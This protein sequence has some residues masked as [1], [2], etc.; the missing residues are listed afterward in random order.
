MAV[1][2]PTTPVA[3]AGGFQNGGWYNGQQYWNGSFGAPGQGNNPNQTDIYGKAAPTQN[4]ADAAYIKQQQAAPVNPVAAPAPVQQQAQPV[5]QPQAQNAAGG[6]T[7]ALPTVPTFDVVAATNAAYNTPEITAAQT[8]ITSRQ[9]A[10]ATA[11]AGINDNPFYSEATR[12]GKLAK[13]TTDA[14]NDIKVQQDNLTMLNANAQVKLNA[15]KDQYNIN[16]DAYKTNLTNFNSLVSQGALDNAS[17]QDIANMAIQTGIPTSMIQSIQAWSV[18][19][20][21]PA[22]K[23]TIVQSTDNSGNLSIMAVDPI[24]GKVIS[25]T[26]IAGAGKATTGAGAPAPKVGSTDYISWAKTDAQ[27]GKTLDDMMAYYTGY[28]DKQQ[29]FDLYMAQNYYK[30]SDTQVAAAKTKWGVK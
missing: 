11:T 20:D 5:A 15:Q 30:N 28:L 14:N 27:S 10:L 19:K 4:A 1:A 29:I 3:P 22:E 2:I 18:K 7:V 23:P 13:L 26:T 24:T 21:N 6:T 25:T 16:S 17:A 9:A 8:A 12:V